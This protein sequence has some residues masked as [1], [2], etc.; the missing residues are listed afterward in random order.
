MNS[1]VAYPFQG[2]RTE[3]GDGGA[4]S[5]ELGILNPGGRSRIRKDTVHSNW[6]R[7]KM[8]HQDPIEE[9]DE[10]STMN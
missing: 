4:G 5:H 6:I 7:K 2:R 9:E 1:G 10:E 8:A 3:T